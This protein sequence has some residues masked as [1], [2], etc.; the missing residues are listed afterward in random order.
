M[1]EVWK[2][3]VGYEKLYEVS[4]LGHV[5]SKRR[6]IKKGCVGYMILKSK[7][8]VQVVGGRAKNYHRVMLTAGRKR[9]AYVHHLVAEAF[10]GPRPSGTK[11]CHKDDKG[12]NNKE[13]NLYYG[14]DE[15]NQTDKHVNSLNLRKMEGAP[16]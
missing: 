5:R 6:L 1:S 11:V 9:H 12:F 3:V 14:T 8:L 15:D 13:T 16:F 2:P 10:H 4:N 7:M